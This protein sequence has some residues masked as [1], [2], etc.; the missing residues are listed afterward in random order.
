MTKTEFKAKWESDDNGGGITFDD[1]AD[2]AV[3]WGICSKPRIKPISEVRYLVLKAANTADAEDYK[4][5]VQK[6]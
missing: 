1:V 5:R 6:R 4:P 2:A 3:T